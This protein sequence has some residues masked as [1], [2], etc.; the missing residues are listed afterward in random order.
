MKNKIDLKKTEDN[1]YD[2]IIGS[3]ILNRIPEILK[4]EN[5]ADNYIIITDSNIKEIYGKDLLNNIKNNNL[6]TTL[7][8]FEAGEQ[9]KNIN[10]VKEI[11]SEMLKNNFDRDSLILALGGGV[12]GDIAGFVASVY[13]RG[14][15]YIQ[16]P[17]SLIAQVDSSIGGKTGINTR[18]GKN[19][20]GTFYQ[21]EKVIIDTSTLKT[22]PKQE[23][24]N[25]LSEVIK[26]ALIKDKDFFNF[27]EKNI[28]TILSLNNGAL[29]HI[30]KRSCEIKKEII[31]KDEKEKHCRKMLNLGHTIGHSLES[32]SSYKLPHGSAVSIGLL[33]EAKISGELGLLKQAEIKQIKS[34]LE[35]CRLPTTIPEFI[36]LKLIIKNTSYDKKAV[37]GEPYYVLLEKIGKAKIGVKV[38]DKIISKV[39]EELK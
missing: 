37:K 38:P 20:L 4:K 9:S 30:I 21:P 31:E 2:I 8:S 29:E 11:L 22:L 17:T 14:I 19:L 13:K 7:I 35:T 15:R 10:T 23:F 25:G 34:L 3:R 1:S 24:I 33:A 16:I 18:Y 32:A 26:H 12:V 27:L 5:P 36:N 39:M 28:N 6:Q